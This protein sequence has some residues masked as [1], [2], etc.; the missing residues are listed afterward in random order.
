MAVYNIKTIKKVTVTN[1]QY[2][3]KGSW[4]YAKFITRI[5]FSVA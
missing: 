5:K 3:Q 2:G 4:R 1:I